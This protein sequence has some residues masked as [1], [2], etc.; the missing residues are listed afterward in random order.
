[1]NRVQ[2]VV[3]TAL[4]AALILAVQQTTP[5]VSAE[6]QPTD[7]KSAPSQQAADTG[8]QKQAETPKTS[9][10]DPVAKV[11]N[12]V[13]TRGEMARAETI[14]LKQNQP[15]QPLTAEQTK[16]V[17]DYVVEQL[18]AAELLYQAGLKVEPKD[19]DKQVAEKVAQGRS[20]FA[21]KEEYENA[22]KAQDIDEKQ[23]TDYTRKEI[24]VNNLIDKEIAPK[25]QVSDE[26]IKKF[27][28]DNRERYFS[29]P[30]QVRASHILIGVDQKAD[31][32]TKKK[33][34]EKAEAL[35]KEVKEGKKDFAELAKANST[36]PSSAQGGDLGFFGKGQMVAP[37]EQAAFALK[38]G[39]V[40][41]VVETQFG[42]HIVKLTDK[43][44]A[45]NV[46]L[47][48]AKP[49]IAEFLKNQKVQ[50]LVTDY[51]NEL[52]S[53]NKVEKLLK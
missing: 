20:R 48:E 38:P 37:F 10:D 30:E 14:L 42:Y 35:L 51:I 21:T 17:E 31:A 40:S 52:R 34:K 49:K 22:L 28:D 32:E 41:G 47:E 6:T 53:K 9:P 12:A 43:K 16:Q 18:I 15:K 26:E 2:K 39:E 27:Y 50:A 46:S 29:K 25:A 45:E 1:M 24:I 36:C 7:Q 33:A 13:I 3:V 5:A 11:G 23:L 4:C 44:P 8:A 19:L